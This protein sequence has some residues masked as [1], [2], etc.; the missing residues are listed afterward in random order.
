[1]AD[2]RLPTGWDCQMLGGC[3]APFV[4]QLMTAACLSPDDTRQPVPGEVPHRSQETWVST[5]QTIACHLLPT[6]RVW[7][8]STLLLE[9]GGLWETV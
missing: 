3:P 5:L 6:L 7:Q 2:T 9:M 8:C 4:A 1:M